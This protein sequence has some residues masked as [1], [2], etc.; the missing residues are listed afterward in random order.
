VGSET[1]G[2]QTTPIDWNPIVQQDQAIINQL[3]NMLPATGTGTGLDTSSLWNQIAT[4]YVDQQRINS[5][6]NLGML[7]YLS[8]L[9]QAGVLSEFQA[10]T[11]ITS[12]MSSAFQSLFPNYRAP[13]FSQLPTADP[14][15]LAQLQAQQAAQEQTDLALQQQA[16]TSGGG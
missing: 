7:P 4:N 6:L 8:P 12:P 3:R 15:A 2:Q 9:Q 16:F 14:A 5:G 11:P 10:P 1:H 13:Q